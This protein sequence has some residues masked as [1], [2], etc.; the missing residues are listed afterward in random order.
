M[1]VADGE[2]GAPT[3]RRRPAAVPDGSEIGT[4]MPGVRCLPLQSAR[5]TSRGTSLRIRIVAYTLDAGPTRYC[6]RDRP[7]HRSRFLFTDP[8]GLEGLKLARMRPLPFFAVAEAF[9]ARYPGGRSEVIGDDLA[10]STTQVPAGAERV[11]GLR[12][13]LRQE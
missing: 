10:G 2:I 11:P 4:G 7:P 8:R 5:S 6:L 13:A 1:G 12:E 3:L 9:L